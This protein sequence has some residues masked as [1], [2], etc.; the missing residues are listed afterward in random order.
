MTEYVDKHL[1]INSSIA[2][3]VYFTPCKCS[4]PSEVAGV[5]MS[6]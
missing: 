2:F 1:L 6:E 3:F 4:K 5:D